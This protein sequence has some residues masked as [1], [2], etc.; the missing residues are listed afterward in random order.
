MATNIAGT[1]KHCG[2]P[3]ACPGAYLKILLEITTAANT[4]NNH[5]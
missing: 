2:D 3:K 5:G 4:K 1:I